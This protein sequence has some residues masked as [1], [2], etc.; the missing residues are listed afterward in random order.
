[1]RIPA[2]VVAK[3]DVS[4]MYTAAIAMLEEEDRS[5]LVLVRR[6]A[7]MAGLTTAS[8]TALLLA[9]ICQ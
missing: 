1:V 9:R 6:A 7:I 2:A 8:K 4:A 5:L 3:E